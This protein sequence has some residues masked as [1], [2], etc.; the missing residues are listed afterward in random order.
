MIITLPRKLDIL[1]LYL[2]YTYRTAR[3]RYSLFKY[4]IL[5]LCFSNIL[6]FY[7]L[8]SVK[9]P[10]RLRISDILQFKNITN[11]YSTIKYIL[12]RILDIPWFNILYSVQYVIWCNVLL[13][14][15]KKLDLDG[16]GSL[17]IE[18]FMSLPKL[19]QNPLV[20]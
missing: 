1:Y 9:K 14:R 2:L 12:L 11:R 7:V 15:F 5:I 20:K 8:S 19:Q 16:S 4:S 10:N 18:E 3:Y 17:S 13:F 6:I